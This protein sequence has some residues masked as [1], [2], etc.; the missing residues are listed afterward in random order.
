MSKTYKIAGVSAL[1]L[2]LGAAAPALAQSAQDSIVNPNAIDDQIDQQR[3]N[4]EQQFDRA[5]DSYRFGSPNYREGLSGSASLGYAGAT[6]NDESQ[7]L[8]IGARLTHKAGPFSQNLS[9]LM[10]FEE[11]DNE[12][13]VK[14]VYGVYDGLYD[15]TP[16]FYGFVMGRVITDGLADEVTDEDL[17]RGV[18]ESDLTQGERDAIIARKIEQDAFI[19]IGPGYRIFDQPD[20]AW[21]LQAGVG[22]SYLKFGD[23]RSESEVGYVLSSRFYW[24]INENVFV[25]MDTDALNSDEALRVNNDLGVNFRI[26]DAFSTRVSYLSD[27]NE[28]RAIRTDNTL[29]VSL[30]YGF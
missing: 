20:L 15:F 22:Q 18:L 21:R 28:S 29:G 30:V 17:P 10:R 23:G 9:F 2:M 6:G 26:T 16:R 8:N 11:D 25:T 13:T 5:N 1:A 4:V 3:F 19:G 7:N 24:G 14:K 12:S 27:Y